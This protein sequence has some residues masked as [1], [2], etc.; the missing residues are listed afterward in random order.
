MT[1]WKG[2]L[3]KLKTDKIKSYIGLAMKAGRIASGEFATE[4]SVKEGRA[5]LV[6]LAKDAS[7]NTKKKFRD[8]CSYYET[9]VLEFESKDELGR[10]IGREERACLSVNDEGFAKA[11]KKNIEEKSI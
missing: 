11:I 2:S 7:S 6:F 9:P 10:I 3:K 1:D 5:F 4:K 8:M